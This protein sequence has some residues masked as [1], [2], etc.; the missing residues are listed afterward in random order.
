M[1]IYIHNNFY[2]TENVKQGNYRANGDPIEGPTIQEGRPARLAPGI[3]RLYE[4]TQYGSPSPNP[5]QT[6][7][8]RQPGN[9]GEE[10][11]HVHLLPA[12]G[13]QPT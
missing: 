3:H 4:K 13:G 6:D 12:G 8:P 2:I 1:Y 11:L 5:Q 9:L 10:E 7:R